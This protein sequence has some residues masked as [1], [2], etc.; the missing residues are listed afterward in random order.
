MC[1]E[2]R[3]RRRWLSTTTVATRLGVSVQ[4]V[5]NWIESGRFDLVRDIGTGARRYYQVESESVRRYEERSM[6]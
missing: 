3:Q 2:F 4:T 1:S 6:I 5:R